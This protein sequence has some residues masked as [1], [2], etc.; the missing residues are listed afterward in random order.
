MVTEGTGPQVGLAAPLALEEVAAA[1][2]ELEVLELIGRGGMGVVYKAKQ[3]SLN[4]LV[5]L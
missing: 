5:A 3:K 2:P 1:V 4:R